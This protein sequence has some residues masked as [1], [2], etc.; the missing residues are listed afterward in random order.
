[1]L[2]IVEF[3]DE[4][5]PL[6]HDINEE[7]ISGMFEMEDVDRHVLQNPRATIID[8]DG[9]ILFVEVEGRGIVGAGAL[10]WSGSGQ[11]ELTKMGVRSDLRGLKA[12]EFLLN[13]LIERAVSMAPERLYLLTNKKCEAA[14]HLYEKCGFEHDADLLAEAQHQYARCDVA[15]TYRG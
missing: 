1:M 10:K 12:G 6:F 11:L 3:R 13:A 7:W 15:M 4:L 8:K 14:I 9:D 5:A 2:R